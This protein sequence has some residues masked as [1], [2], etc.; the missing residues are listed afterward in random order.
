VQEGMVCDARL[1]LNIDMPPPF[2]IMPSFV[3]QTATDL[4]VNTMMSVL[5]VRCPYSPASLVHG[6]LLT[7]PQF[8]TRRNGLLAPTNS[9]TSDY[10]IFGLLGSWFGQEVALSWLYPYPLITHHYKAQ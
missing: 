8:Q 10:S 1:E 5:V 3:T 7:P 9:L 6:P 2:S 4:A